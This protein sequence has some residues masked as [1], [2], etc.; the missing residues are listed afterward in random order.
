MRESM[1]TRRAIAA[2]CLLIATASLAACAPAV[3]PMSDSLDRMLVE[4]ERAAAAAHTASTARLASYLRDKWGPVPLPDRGIERWVAASEWAPTVAA[5]LESEGVAG[6]LVAEGGERLDFSGVRTTEPRL[7]YALDVATFACQ[8][9]YP[10][11][12][13]FERV[14]SEVEA[15]W[16]REFTQSVVTPCLLAAGYLVAP[17]P[18][19]EQFTATWRT[20]EQFDPY[21]LVGESI[22][23]RARAAATCP[24]ADAVLEA[25]P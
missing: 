4:R 22:A 7:L 20:D 5:C 12:S 23:E 15:P 16:A 17:L 25:L 14:T 19:D 13:W 1:P 2:V 6:V 11:L 21:A 8:S 3:Q 9:Q 10:V 18:A 24:S